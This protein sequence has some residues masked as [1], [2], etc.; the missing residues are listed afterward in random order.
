MAAAAPDRGCPVWCREGRGTRRSAVATSGRC[1]GHVA[2]LTRKISR[3][4]FEPMFPEPTSDLAPRATAHAALGDPAR[5]Q[6][7]DMLLV[8][9]ASPSELAAMLG[10]PSTL[11]ARRLCVLERAGII[12]AAG[13]RRPP[14]HLP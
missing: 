5:L 4:I 11:L 7:T 3:S 10:M 9:D 8:G 13:R 1:T 12:P 14:P 2:K 6:I